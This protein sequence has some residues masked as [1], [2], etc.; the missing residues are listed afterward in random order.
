MLFYIATPVGPG[1][2]GPARVPYESGH[3]RAQVTTGLLSLWSGVLLLSIF[4][5]LFEINLLSKV[6]AA[7]PYSAEEANFSYTSL[8]VLG[9][10]EWL[11][12]VG[13]VISF[14]L[15]FH[16]AYRNL[17]ALG[18]IGLKYSPAWA[19][20]AFF[21][22]LLNL[23]RPF[24]IMREIWQVSTATAGRWVNVNWEAGSLPPVLIGWWG[25]W[26]GY[27]MF[28]R[29][30]GQLSQSGTDY[31]MAIWADRLTIVTC[32]AGLVAAVLFIRI[33]REVD[34]GQTAR[35]Q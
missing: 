32:M 8:W 21:V 7:T 3:W 31:S 18:A 2:E 24:Q 17:P 14:L 19:V 15:W 12:Y 30:A 33:I 23:V 11:F 20:G 6:L 35:Q 13:I 25:T 26:W 1:T 34:R 22:P 4:A 29:M 16:R 27:I 9:W 5:R 28:G 10:A